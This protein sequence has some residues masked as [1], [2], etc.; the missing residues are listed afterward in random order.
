MIKHSIKKWN[1]CVVNTQCLL[2][3][4]LQGV[5]LT[6]DYFTMY[7]HMLN[8][9]AATPNLYEYYGFLYL[10][11]VFA[12]PTSCVHKVFVLSVNKKY[13]HKVTVVCIIELNTLVKKKVELNT[14]NFM[15]YSHNFTKRGITDLV[16][17]TNMFLF[18]PSTSYFYR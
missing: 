6:N 1:R 11:M 5:H 7:M 18:F 3:Q 2:G 9:E 4:N 16:M 14:N 10:H 15:F 12:T 13:S 8:G 17:S